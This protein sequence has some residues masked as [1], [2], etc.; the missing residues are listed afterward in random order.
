MINRVKVTK[1]YDKLSNI[2]SENES[3]TE[4]KI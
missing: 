3:E 2:R 1:L 4:K